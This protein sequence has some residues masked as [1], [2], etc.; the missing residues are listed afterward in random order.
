MCAVSSLIN[1]I[2]LLVTAVL[3]IPIRTMTT[4]RINYL[5]LHSV[6]PGVRQIC[7]NLFEQRHKVFKNATDA[8]VECSVL[9]RV[10]V[11]DVAIYRHFAV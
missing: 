9:D 1:V 2:G 8:R 3:P 5:A 11:I 4:I 7:Q 6:R 10:Q